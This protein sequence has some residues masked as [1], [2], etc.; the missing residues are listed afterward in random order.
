MRQHRTGAVVVAQARP[1]GGQL[2]HLE[3]ASGVVSASLKSRVMAQMSR[4]CCSTR[5]S[6][7]DRSPERR[8]APPAQ[9]PKPCA[10][11]A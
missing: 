4:A 9:H 3:D 6:H 8:A 2:A 5:R 7:A 1:S 10:A 11:P